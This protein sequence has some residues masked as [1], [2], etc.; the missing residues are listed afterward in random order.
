M[1]T[2]ALCP[3]RDSFA[4]P[5]DQYK[6]RIGQPFRLLGRVDPATYD[7]EECG[8]MYWIEFVDGVRIEAWPEEIF[9]GLTSP[10]AR[11]TNPNR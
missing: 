7:R 11:D 10:N 2:N 5:Y 1:T 6:D 8:P 9:D 3:L 4:S